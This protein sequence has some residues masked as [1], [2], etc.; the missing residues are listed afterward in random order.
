[1]GG[2]DCDCVHLRCADMEDTQYCPA[3]SCPD[4]QTCENV[5][6]E[7]VCIEEETQSE[8]HCSDSEAPACGGYCRPGLECIYTGQDT[9]AC[10]A[11]D[12]GDIDDTKYC[13][14]GN[15]PDGGQCKQVG[16]DC[17]C[18]EET[19]LACSESDDP[20]CLGECN[21]GMACMDHTGYCMCDP[22][23]SQCEDGTDNDN[24]GLFDCDDPNCE[25]SD[26]CVPCYQISP[27]QCGGSCEYG[28]CSWDGR[29]CACS[30]I[31]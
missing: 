30:G 6:G 18:V 10:Q 11:M 4:G 24:D 8:L 1:M 16:R 19:A 29:S 12:C 28:E 17:G 22:D 26:P 23:D 27:G 13:E 14:L 20:A 31:M 7:C 15:C 3:A 21:E 2:A 25:N 5:R 9:C